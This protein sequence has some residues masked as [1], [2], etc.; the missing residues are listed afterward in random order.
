M[1]VKIFINT[2]CYSPPDNVNVAKIYSASVDPASFLAV[3]SSEYHDPGTKSEIVM[4]FCSGMTLLLTKVQSCC[5]FDRYWMTKKQ[6]GQPPLCQLLRLMLTAVELTDR[7]SLLSG[8]MGA[9]MK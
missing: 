5:P 8:A 4:L 1:V 2:R 3:V 9:A 6:I 7:K